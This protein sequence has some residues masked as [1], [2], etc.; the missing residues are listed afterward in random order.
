[1]DFF[2]IIYLCLIHGIC[3]ITDYREKKIKNCWVVAVFIGAFFFQVWIWDGQVFKEALG[4]MFLFFLVLFP[5]YI[6]QAIG[7]G[8]VKLLCATAF[9]MGREN[10]E[11]FLVGTLISAGIFAVV[12][13]LYCGTLRKRMWYFWGYMR[14]ILMTG[15]IESYG[16]PK[17]KGEVLCMAVPIFIAVLGWGI[18]LLIPLFYR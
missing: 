6:I 2:R 14:D 17:Q 15:R 1:M 8:D 11:I 9:Y 7:A 4:I 3:M 18:Y 5:L 16:I 10:I 12:K 13:L